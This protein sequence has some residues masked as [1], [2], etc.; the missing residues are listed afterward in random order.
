MMENVLK[1]AGEASLSAGVMILAVLTLRA[2]F[3]DRTP[4]RAFCLLWDMVLV[5]L[6]V[7]G[8][9]PRR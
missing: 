5:R 4:S 9:C 8:R 6:L 7:L 1:A 2:W 3:Q